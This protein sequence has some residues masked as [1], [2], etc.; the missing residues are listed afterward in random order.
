MEQFEKTEKEPE[1]EAIEG[2]IGKYNENWQEK[3]PPGIKPEM[4]ERVLERDGWHWHL[5]P[6]F[7]KDEKEREKYLA[8][9][10]Q[11]EE[12]VEEE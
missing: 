4:V 11:W 1:K 6:E 7:I 10:R 8:E 3:L 9:K 5:K 2:F 12:A